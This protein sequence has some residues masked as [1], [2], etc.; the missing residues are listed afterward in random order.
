MLYIKLLN[1]KSVNINFISVSEII[2][3]FPLNKDTTKT[4]SKI[5]VYL[6]YNVQDDMMV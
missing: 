3:G 2:A 5:I 4:I 1:K 6:L